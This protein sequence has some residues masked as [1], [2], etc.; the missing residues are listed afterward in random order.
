MNRPIE[1]GLKALFVIQIVSSFLTGA[2]GL[3]APALI[4]SLSGLDLKATPAIQQAGALSLGYTLGA[5]M[6]LRATTWGEVRIFA[7][8]SLIAFALSLVGAFY[9]V[10]IAGV[11]AIGLIVILLASLIMTV[12]LGYYHLR[13]GRAP[14]HGGN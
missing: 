4:I 9:Y 10:V 7:A 6:A 13:Y 1:S 8:G 2:L 14:G 11:V 5:L 3:F 12:G